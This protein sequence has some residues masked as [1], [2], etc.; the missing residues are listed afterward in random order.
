MFAAFHAPLR[1]NSPSYNGLHVAAIRDMA[2]PKAAA[3]QGLREV[4]PTRLE[5]DHTTRFI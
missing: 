4:N 1:E 3:D 5:P 2:E